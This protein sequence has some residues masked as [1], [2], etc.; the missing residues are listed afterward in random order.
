MV[1]QTLGQSVHDEYIAKHGRSKLTYAAAQELKSVTTIEELRQLCTTDVS[2]LFPDDATPEEMIEAWLT[3]APATSDAEELSSI[4]ATSIEGCVILLLAFPLLAAG[5]GVGAVV[6]MAGIDLHVIFGRSRRTLRLVNLVLTISSAGLVVA[7]K[8]DWPMGLAIP[9]FILS[10]VCV[11][12]QDRTAW[13]VTIAAFSILAGLVACIWAVKY[14]DASFLW[15]GGLVCSIGFG[16]GLVRTPRDFFAKRTRRVLS[17]R[18]SEG[19]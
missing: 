15:V 18:G 11:G 1:D 12:F 17:R 4:G 8:V 9:A 5:L 10:G 6:R 7:L 19:A 2:A 13:D 3:Y 16:Y 14:F